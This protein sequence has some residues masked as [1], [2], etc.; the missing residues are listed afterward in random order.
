VVGIFTGTGIR[1]DEVH[2]LIVSGRNLVADWSNGQ[3][4]G[5]ANRWK[6]IKHQMYGHANFSLLRARVLYGS[7]A[8][9]P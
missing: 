4:E 9:S 2:P 8:S 1:R 5:Q 7:W 3:V 6:L